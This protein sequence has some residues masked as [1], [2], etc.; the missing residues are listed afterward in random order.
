M[1]APRAAPSR[2]R[3]A[4]PRSLS[5][6]VLLACA[7]AVAPAT[8]RAGQSVD[9]SAVHVGPQVAPGA[10]F[11]SYFKVTT[12]AEGSVRLGVVVANPLRYRCGVRLVGAYGLTALNSGDTYPVAPGAGPGCVQTSCWLSGV[13]VTVSVGAGGRTVVPFVVSVPAGTP[14]GEY[15][16]GV[17]AAP[18]TPPAQPQNKS[19]APQV[20]AA[21]VAHVA[22][23][24]AVTVPGP[25]TPRLTI[26]TVKLERTSPAAILNVHEHDAGNTW[27]H[28]AGRVLIRTG[29]RLRE[30]PL[31][32]S[33]I[34]PRGD[35]TLPLVVGT[36]PEGTWPTEVDLWYDHH[37]KEAVWR[38]EIGYPKPTRGQADGQGEVTTGSGLPGWVIPLIAGLVAV[39]L[40]LALVLLILLYKRRRREQDAE[41]KV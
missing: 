6:L 23:G 19:G 12:Q 2:R 30:L 10:P 36:I 26:P 35:A 20:G 11:A 3:Y 18:S 29:Q 9:C 41:V 13:P 33:T 15:L 34:L 21:V 32:S 28:P 24:V 17:V 22:I 16:A 39:C 1:S 14:S 4:V 37:L 25:L 7:C 38:G 27:E 5:L 31:R 8:A 40:I